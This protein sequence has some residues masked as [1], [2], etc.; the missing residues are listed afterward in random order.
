MD[1][2]TIHPPALHPGDT[3][4]VIAPASTI[5]QRDTLD[6]G[7]AT[8]ERMG[9]SVR[10]NERIF[11]TSRYL[12]GDDNARAEELM[13]SF[14]DS[15]VHAII[16]L[17]GGYGCARLLPL[18][19]KKRL[20]PYP[21]I[22]MGFSDLTTLQLYF[23]RHFGWITIHGP[24]A[25]SKTLGNISI[26]EE[27]HLFSLLTNPDY[28]PELNFPQLEI[29]TP[30]VA[31]GILVGGCLAVVVTSLGTPYEIKTEGKILFLEDLGE[32]PYKLDRM[33]THLRLAGKLDS[34]A[35]ILLGSF[36]DCDPAHGG[37]T[38]NETLK[39]FVND[40]GVPVLANFPAGHGTNNWAIPLGVKV[41]MD[42]STRSL[43]FL[44]PAVQIK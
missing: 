30:G 43:Q 40:F 7:I 16:A 2:P 5:E 28:L 13:S 35:G 18:L 23:R 20:R 37:Y 26:D 38:A 41:R 27:R 15:S 33:L 6:Q 39:D 31:E 14:E 34:I 1:I 36:L 17:R 3:I 12:A 9:F 25:A 19:K 22:F 29:W 24:M 32:E 10:F 44:E 4:A 42:A 21:K 8:L 11:Q